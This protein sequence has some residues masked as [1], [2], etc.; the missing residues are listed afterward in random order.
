MEQISP[1][2]TKK[3]RNDDSSAPMELKADI[4]L[5]QRET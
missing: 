4:S 5:Q 2:A 1:K 3:C